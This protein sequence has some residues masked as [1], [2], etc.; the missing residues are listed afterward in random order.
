MRVTLKTKLKIKLLDQND[1]KDYKFGSL[2][3]LIILNRGP[4]PLSYYQL[5]RLNLNF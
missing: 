2:F 4:P 5:Y 1:L 3:S